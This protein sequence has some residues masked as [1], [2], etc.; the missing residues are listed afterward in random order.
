MAE[1]NTH[2][3]YSAEDIERYLKGKMSAKEM[4][5][6]E[7]AALQDPFLADA[8][9]GLSNVSF[10][11]SRKHLNEITASL[12]TKKEEPKVVSLPSKSF[13]WW[14]V[15]AIIIFVAGA[16][17]ASWY[18]IG[19]NASNESG[20]AQAKESKSKA[21]DTVVNKELKNKTI[22]SDSLQALLAQNGVPNASQEEKK[23][24]GAKKQ[25]EV[26]TR[27]LAK[28]QPSARK[29]PDATIADSFIAQ[30]KDVAT[31]ISSLS[32][33]A[34]DDTQRLQ[35]TSK[36]TNAKGHLLNDDA[37]NNFTGRVTDD[38][39]QPVALA[40]IQA[41]KE[42]VTTDSNGY[43]KLRAQDSVLNVTVSSA[44][45]V[46]ANRELRS[47]TTNNISIKPDKTVLS[48]TRTTLNAAK[49]KRNL[50]DSAYPSGGWE[51][52]QDYV[53]K[54]LGKSLDTLNDKEITGDVQLEFSIDKNGVPY[55]FIVLKSLNDKAASKAIELIREGPRWITAS[56]SKKGRVTI[57]F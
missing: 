16:G 47:Y 40:I 5:D 34:P 9:E 25:E 54:K 35:E 50:A 20:I 39:N 48:E 55:N 57:Q 43:F 38:N 26:A 46:S 36:V 14:R 21:P 12:Q 2:I 11:E 37:L 27:A 31:D 13:Y 45:F 28:T 7:K 29:I 18:I 52:F 24:N 19:S 4:H 1:Q 8:I 32:A 22:K 56:K 49:A 17:V 51:L 41:D 44:G 15:A 53:S 33:R 42:S 6:M 23:K 30:N 3:N 10:E